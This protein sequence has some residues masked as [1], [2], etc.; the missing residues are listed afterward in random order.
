M[1]STQYIYQPLKPKE[2]LLFY[3]TCRKFLENFSSNLDV[4]VA[5]Y[6]KPEKEFK[7]LSLQNIF[8]QIIK[9]AANARRRSHVIDFS[10]NSDSQRKNKLLKAISG[11]SNLADENPGLSDAKMRKV[12]HQL[13]KLDVDKVFNELKKSQLFEGNSEKLR[14][15]WLRTIKEAASFVLTFKSGRSFSKFFSQFRGR[16]IVL[17][18]CFLSLHIYGI[19]IALACD[20]LK[21]LGIS[22]LIKPDQHIKDVFYALNLVKEKKS[23]VAVIEAALQ[24]CELANQ[25]RLHSDP[26]ITPFELD[27][28]IW[29]CC[30]GD[31]YKHPHVKA[32][33]KKD[34]LI[35]ELKQAIGR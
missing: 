8:L 4:D 15:D 31:F 6:L 35:L 24:L 34:Q 18:P 32:T 33:R 13:E 29:L 27:R 23:D 16:A 14:K 20:A 2:S 3:N 17:G 21:D 11:I 7:H 5:D 1:T 26:E 9:S 25:V 12:L 19:G 30:S 10:D 22:Q 28:I